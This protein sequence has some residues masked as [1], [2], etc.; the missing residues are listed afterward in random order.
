MRIK[1]RMKKNSLKMYDKWSVL[2]VETIKN[3]PRESKIY[4][5]VEQREKRVTRWVPMGKSVFH[6][7]RYAEAMRVIWGHYRHLYPSTIV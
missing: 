6:L 5:K 4:R 1:H 3:N 7:Y 2:R